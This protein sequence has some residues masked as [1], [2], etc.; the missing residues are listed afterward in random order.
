LAGGGFHA[1]HCLARHPLR[2]CLA[3]SN[4]PAVEKRKRTEEVSERPCL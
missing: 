2:A 4:T 1:S 3:K